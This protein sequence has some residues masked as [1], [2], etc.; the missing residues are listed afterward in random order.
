[1]SVEDSNFV[2]LQRNPGGLGIPS[3]PKTVW[4]LITAQTV[5]VTRAE[6][7]HLEHG[8]EV[9]MRK[10]N[11][12]QRFLEREFSPFADWVRGYTVFSGR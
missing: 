3:V 9:K 8:V 7:P 1:M 12:E 5:W 11:Q 6:E 4:V 2:D 10:C